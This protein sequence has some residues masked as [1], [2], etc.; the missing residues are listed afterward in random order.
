MAGMDTVRRFQK[1]DL[2]IG[3]SMLVVGLALV[4]VH[5]ARLNAL[6]ILSVFAWPLLFAGVLKPFK[7]AWL[8]FG[9]GFSLVFVVFAYSLIHR[10]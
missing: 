5:G 9:L 6:T 3:I 7:R 1:N 8:G 10:Y 2:L 4:T